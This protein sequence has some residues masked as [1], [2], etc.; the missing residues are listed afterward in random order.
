MPG[1]TD[2]SDEK[3]KRQSSPSRRKFI[4]D[5]SVAAT[6]F[7]I[8]PRHVL[9]RGYIAPSDKLN[10]AAIGVGGKGRENL[11]LAFNKGAETIAALCDVDDRQAVRARKAWPKAPYY[12]DFRQMLDKEG[13]RIDAVIISTPDH[14]HAVMAMPAMQLGKHVY[15]EKPLTHDIY[16]ARMLT[17]ATK[18]YRVVTQMGNQG[19]SGDDTRKVEAWVQGGAIGEVSRVHVWTNRP[20]WPQGVDVPAGNF[21]IPKELDWDLWL[22][23][24]PARPYTPAY[25]PAIWRGCRRSGGDG[26]ISAPARLAIWVAIL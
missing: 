23:T 21:E 17:E 18:K 13:K 20:A 16:E 25:L 14:M 1:P 6:G 7:F 24:A 3:A 26:W 9:G 8:V 4:R 12:R 2:C 19:S 22:G 15:L 10:I 5:A 11:D